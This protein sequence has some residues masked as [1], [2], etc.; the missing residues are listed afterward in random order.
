M[1]VPASEHYLAMEYPP[2]DTLHISQAIRH[3]IDMPFHPASYH[4]TSAEQETMT[5]TY[6]GY[7]SAATMDTP[8]HDTGTGYPSFPWAS[9]KEKMWTA[10][11]GWPS[12]VDGVGLADASPQVS[13]TNESYDPTSM[14]DPGFLEQP[15]AYADWQSTAGDSAPSGHPRPMAPQPMPA[16]PLVDNVRPMPKPNSAADREPV[17]SVSRDS[18]RGS[19]E[20]ICP[21]GCNRKVSAPRIGGR[22]AGH[23]F[24][25]HAQL[26]NQDQIRCPIEGCTETKLINSSAYH[27]HYTAHLLDMV[28]TVLCHQ[29]FMQPVPRV[30]LQQH[31][32]SSAH[33]KNYR[34]TASS[35][36]ASLP[37]FASGEPS[38]GV[39]WYGAAGPGHTEV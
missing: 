11:A 27:S 35:S 2:A 13:V 38:G 24:G 6:L 25:F 5:A 9:P 7:D 14:L 39:G 20:V 23:L 16:P 31:L 22:H 3:E 19:L 21:L 37:E 4:T 26:R 32:Q 1:Y 17:W 12:G 30:E 34:P 33:R 8:Y 10:H 18:P 36:T 29:C 15:L 28:K